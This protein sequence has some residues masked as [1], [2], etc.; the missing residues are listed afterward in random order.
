MVFI[1]L[2]IITGGLRTVGFLGCALV[3]HVAQFSGQCAVA[4][5]FV[6]SCQQL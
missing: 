4:L 5:P 2:G 6:P 3:H 1:P